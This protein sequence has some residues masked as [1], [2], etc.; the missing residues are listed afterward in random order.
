[1]KHIPGLFKGFQGPPSFSSTFNDL[2]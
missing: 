2:N 1:M